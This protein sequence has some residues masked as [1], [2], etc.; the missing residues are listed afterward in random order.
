MIYIPNYSA[1]YIFTQ[2]H[3]E[4][5]T[6]NLMRIIS[7]LLNKIN[8]VNKKIKKGSEPQETIVINK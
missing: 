7:T 3:K 2:K 5:H 6:L 1:N 8:D 4:M